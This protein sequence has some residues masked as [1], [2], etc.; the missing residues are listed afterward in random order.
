MINS[1]WTGLLDIVYPRN[2][3]LC[4]AYHPATARDP[5]C[6]AC[7]GR[8]PWNTPPFCVR[9]SRHLESV[10]EE[11]LCPSCRAH[12]PHFD[13]G[14]ALLRYEGTARELLHKFKFQDKTSLRRTFA[15]LLG[16]FIARYG[17]DFPGCHGV[18]PVPLHEVRLRERGYNQAALLAAG[19][20]RELA[21]PLREDVLQ[22]ARHT[23]RQSGLGAKERW[24]NIEGAFRIKNPAAIA[25]RAA[26][27]VDDVLTTSAT[28]SEA[29]KTLK[30][31]GASRV[32]LI[33]LAIAPCGSC[34]I[35]S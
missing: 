31:A 22:R 23:P 14:W 7:R 33:T 34:A 5:L 25:G 30:D 27:L 32:T 8:L 6:P 21:L 35:T 9:C 24:T 2:C 15:A 12:P 20:A 10:S 11:G 13:E 28:A 16:E 1:I 18:I 17:L 4:K 3:V 19:V 26:I 29:A